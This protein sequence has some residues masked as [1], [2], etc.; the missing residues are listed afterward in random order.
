MEN[1]IELSIYTL[2]MF[3]MDKYDNRILLDFCSFI[4]A[5]W[6]LINIVLEKE[7]LLMSSK[8]YTNCI[9]FIKYTFCP[10]I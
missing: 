6:Y 4:L 9:L 8:Y 5:I 7:L 10:A 2:N 3:L 1:K